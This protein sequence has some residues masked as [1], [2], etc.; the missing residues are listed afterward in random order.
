MH[1]DMILPI[2]QGKFFG[3]KTVDVKV[4]FGYIPLSKYMPKYIKPTRKINKITCSFKTCISS[5]SLQSDINKWRL[6]PLAKLDK[7]C[8]NSTSTRILQIEFFK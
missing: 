5:M 2:S 6:S 1:N 8:I 7:L 4:C 3:A